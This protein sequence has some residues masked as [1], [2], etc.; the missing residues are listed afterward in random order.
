MKKKSAWLIGWEA[1]TQKRLSQIKGPRIVAF[2]DGR[3]SEAIIRK[4]MF[5][6]YVS[7]QGL[8]LEEK[9]SYGLENEGKRILQKIE[10][11]DLG[12]VRCGL[13]PWVVAR[14]V[15][16]LEVEKLEDGSTM[17]RWNQRAFTFPKPG[18]IPEQYFEQ[19]SECIPRDN[20]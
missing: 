7:S 19:K 16:D 2:L 20:P 3:K 11:F 1:S 8:T 14:L 6:I 10:E 4:I 12:R 17:I 5:G 13:D 18:A 15:T 9:F